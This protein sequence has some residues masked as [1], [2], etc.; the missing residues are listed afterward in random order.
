MTEIVTEIAKQK[1]K[2][3]AELLDARR[4]RSPEEKATADAAWCN[5][6]A[7]LLSPDMQVAAYNPLGSEPGGSEF[8]H[9][10]AQACKAV[11]LPISG[12]DGQLY[13]ALYEG[14]ESLQPGA[15]GIAEPT[16][17]RFPSSILAELDFIFAPAMA[18]DKSGYRLGKGA[19]Y[20]DRALT[21]LVPGKP[22]VIAMVHSSEVRDVPKE[23]HDRPVDVILTERGLVDIE[24]DV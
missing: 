1:H 24:P 12:D 16:G 11:Y 7:Q 18:V 2:L 13:W 21:P 3:R 15:L 8:V 9:T 20:Y 22:K 23:E 19:G 4:T 17:E 14:P 6:A 10:L 5:A